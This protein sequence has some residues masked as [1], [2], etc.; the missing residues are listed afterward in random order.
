MADPTIG[1]HDAFII[2]IRM[3][4]VHG[5]NPKFLPPCKVMVPTDMISALGA[6]LDVP[7]SADVRFV[8]LEH[9]TEELLRRKS[10]DSSISTDSTPSLTS[11][12]RVLYANSE[13]LRHRSPY[14]ADLFQGDFAETMSADKYKTIIV[15]GADFNTVYWMLRCV[16]LLSF[17]RCGTDAVDSC[18]P[19]S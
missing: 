11:R 7:S 8:C 5:Y 16:L 14:F 10:G 9:R 15:D 17:M 2:C 4:E 6:L 12:K 13:I 3:E 18:I 19:T 1:L